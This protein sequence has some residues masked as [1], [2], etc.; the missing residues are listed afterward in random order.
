MNQRAKEEREWQLKQL[1]K[2]EQFNRW[3]ERRYNITAQELIARV[4]DGVIRIN[5]NTTVTPQQMF[6]FYQMEQSLNDDVEDVDQ[7]YIDKDDLKDQMKDRTDVLKATS[8]INQKEYLKSILGL[9]LVKLGVSLATKVGKKL[10]QDVLSENKRQ[11]ALNLKASAEIKDGKVKPSIW[12]SSKVKE[13]I[14]AN[15]KTQNF[16]NL[17]WADVDALKA[18]VDNVVSKG[19]AAGTS[20]QEMAEYLQKHLR[21]DVTNKKYLTERLAR[22]ESAKA[23]FQVQRTMAK[24]QGFEYVKWHAEPN[25]CPTCWGISEADTTKYGAGVYDINDVPDIPQ[26]PNCRCSISTYYVKDN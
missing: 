13:L 24:G 8:M 11:N 15:T 16:S 12:S 1:A 6:D 22:T 25:A 18:T 14:Y 9:I 10:G 20:N 26:H 4:H 3:I 21:K 5:K 19:V 17:L 7:E 23:E 2:D